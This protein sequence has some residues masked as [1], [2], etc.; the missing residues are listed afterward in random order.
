MFS[1]NF[2]EA[3]CQN[4]PPA[5]STPSDSEDPAVTEAIL[6]AMATYERLFPNPKETNPGADSP[7]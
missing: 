2:Y 4:P 6:R 3:L 1:Y 5:S 7:T